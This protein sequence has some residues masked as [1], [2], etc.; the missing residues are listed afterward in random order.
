MSP[1][2][3]K[4]QKLWRYKI[5]ALK[6]LDP[7]TMFQG[8]SSFLVSRPVRRTRSFVV[9][10]TQTTTLVLPAI[11]PVGIGIHHGT[12]PHEYSRRDPT[13]RVPV[14]AVG[15][16]AAYPVWTDW[17]AGRD[18]SIPDNGSRRRPPGAHRYTY[19][20]INVTK[21]SAEVYERQGQGW[22]ICG[23]RGIQQL[24]WSGG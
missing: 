19:I 24:K 5:A 14:S 13:V 8:L 1:T 3:A 6:K 17:T 16:P 11:F 7:D 10:T 23:L 12:N 15:A 20:P 9:F 4:F 18:I 22:W 2:K 21:E